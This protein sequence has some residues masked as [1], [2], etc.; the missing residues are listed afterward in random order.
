MERLSFQ[1]NSQGDDNM[2]N[3]TFY[4]IKIDDKRFI[5]HN[6]FSNKP[7]T[8][9]DIE[10]ATKFDTIEKVNAYIEKFG[11]TGKP[12]LAKTKVVLISG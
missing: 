12:V 11:V 5:S 9:K 4:L 6:W 7:S 2:R 8:S 1:N 10:W 3:N